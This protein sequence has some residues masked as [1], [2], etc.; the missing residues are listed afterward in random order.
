M[1]Q[2]RKRPLVPA[3]RCT[4]RCS[5]PMTIRTMPHSL[6][7]VMIVRDEARCIERCLAS[8]Q[9]WVDTM[10]VLDTGS[11]DDTVARARRAGAQVHHFVWIDDFA[12]A[13]NAALAHCDTDWRLVLDADEWIESGAEC[14]VALRDSG[15][16]FIGQI[17]V[18]SRFGAGRDSG[19]SPCWL[20]R[21]L[22]RGARYRGRIHEQPDEAMKRRR[23][24]LVVGHDG[25]LDENLQAKAGR[26][27]RLLRRA[28]AE[29]PHDAYVRY[30]L[31]KDLE[32]RGHFDAAVPLYEQAHAQTAANAAWRHDLVLRLIFSLKKLG[33]FAQAMLLVE[34]ELPFWP[35]SPDFYF[36]LGD[37]LLDWAASEPQRGP[38]LLPMIESAWLQALTI[39][40]NPALH[41]TV[42]GRGSY[43][44][45]HNLAV[46]H[47]SLGHAAQAQGW[48]D[49]EQLL[50]RVPLA[51]QATTA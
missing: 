43:L 36:T 7:L 27:E 14:L 51:P 15:T 37:L 21:V 47:A 46:L 1:E 10:I 25:Y 20:S 12:A 13:R 30:Q 45:A 3:M 44:A 49:R 5:G 33:R 17:Q 19:E 29:Q 48:R 41:D 18:T 24:S 26:N 22:P 16:D 23:L 31:A 35:T 8:A 2:H 28:M 9:P 42:R 11:R 50:R 34:R 39:G 4:L 32:L 6:A 38:A 40:E